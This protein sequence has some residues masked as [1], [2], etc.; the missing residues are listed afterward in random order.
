MQEL[1][2][3][4][5]KIKDRAST[6]DVTHNKIA[7]IPD[8]VLEFSVLQRLLLT[9]NVLIELPASIGNLSSLKV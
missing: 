8:F 9:D 5:A 3:D 2:L 1:P 7:R 4:V 6:L